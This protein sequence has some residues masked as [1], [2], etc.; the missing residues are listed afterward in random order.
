MSRS[1]RFVSA[2]VC[3]AASG[4]FIP[5]TAAAETY[6]DRLEWQVRPLVLVAGGP[7]ADNWIERLRGERCALAERRIHWLV[8]EEDGTVDRKSVV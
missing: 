6:W 2:L 1:V 3:L 4:A 7:S 5:S 8:I